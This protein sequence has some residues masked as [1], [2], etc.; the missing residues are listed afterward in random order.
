MAEP[1]WAVYCTGGFHHVDFECGFFV[2]NWKVID[3]NSH[4]KLL[5][6]MKNV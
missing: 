2:Y 1:A 5:E 4:S 6:Y 3:Y